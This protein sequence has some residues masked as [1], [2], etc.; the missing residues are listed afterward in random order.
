MVPAWNCRR[1]QIQTSDHR[2]LYQKGAEFHLV[3]LFSLVASRGI[4]LDSQQPIAPGVE[5]KAETTVGEAVRVSKLDHSLAGSLAWSVVGNWSSQVFS[6]ASFLIVARLLSPADFGV[7][8]MAV[9]LFVYLRYLGEF[10]ITQTVVT[11]RHLTDH[12][13]AQL[14][15]IAA[16]LGVACFGLSCALAYPVALFFKTPRVVP[17]V[18]VTCVAL[19]ALGLRAV[20]E[21]LLNKDLR[22]RWLSLV[23]A[24]CR[25]LAAAATLVLALLG[26]AYWALVLGNLLYVL[27][28]TALVV[29]ARPHGF[30]LP[31]LE[32][33]RKELLF[34]WH[35]LVATFA[36]ASY[37]KLDN[38]T[39]GRTLG[40]A[41]LGLY[42]MA[43]NLANI[44]LEKVTSLVVGVIPSYFAAVQNDPAA[45]R[46]YLRGLSEALALATFPAT[47]GLA[48]VARELVPFAL[49]RKWLGM[50]PALEVLCVYVS[51]R[52][53]VALLDRVLTAVGNPRFV[54]WTQLWALA[55]LPCA[56]YVGSHWGITGIA[57]GWVAA[58]PLVALPL[59][60]KVFRT[61]DMR[62]AEYFRA[63]RPAV[64]ATVVM[65]LSVTGLKW[66]LPSS[67][68]L[69]LRLLL[70][71]AVG[72]TAYIATMLLLHGGRARTF[73]SMAKGLRRSRE[74]GV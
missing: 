14:N 6:W 51:F 41:A 31:R 26:F 1:H 33:I 36:W 5:A 23:E 69:L 66:I 49:G 60:R 35:T 17:V 45:L 37:E 65:A 63:L 59:Y 64:D 18:V 7:V 34:G 2:Q 20:P 25:L 32:S 29:K 73:L 67:G 24:G 12:Q 44:P 61:I 15:S 10:G 40:Q 19:V 71:I 28:R 57:L 30:A 4:V 3:R 54:M 39:A 70:E 21:G 68:P 11:L 56:F 53:L 43:W 72:A 22:F 50:V 8:S 16:S 9:I 48:L 42:G 27:V 55:I 13:L 38:V 74:G 46:R 62:F 47:I 52:S 58:Y